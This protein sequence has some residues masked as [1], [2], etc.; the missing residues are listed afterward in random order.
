MNAIRLVVEDDGK[1]LLLPIDFD[2]GD[3]IKRGNPY[4][5]THVARRVLR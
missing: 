1:S 5:A 4:E 3:Y 2:V